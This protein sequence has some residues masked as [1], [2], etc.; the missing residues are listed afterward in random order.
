MN[1]AGARIEVPALAL[2]GVAKSYG[3]TRALLG[4]D[5]DLGR[6]EVLG[7]MGANGA[8]KSTLAKI[9]CGVERADAGTILLEGH[10]IAPRSPAEA[11]SAGIVAVH[12]SIAD[13]GVAAL[14]VTD[15]L[16]LDELCSGRAPILLRRAGLRAR[17]RAMA[18]AVGLEVNLDKKL[19]A[20]SIADRQL[21]AIARAVAQDP[22]VMLFDEPTAS[23][24]SAESG[25]LFG[26]I[27][28]LRRRGVAI[29]Y[30][31]HKTGDLRRLADRC[32]VLRDGQVAGS[33]ARPIDFDAAIGTMVGRA[34]AGVRPRRAR[35]AGG[36][37]VLRLAGARL[38][39]GEAEFDL[40]VHEGEV[41]AVTGPVGAGKTSLAGAIFGRWAL[42]AGSME[43]DG[44]PWAP[45]DPA[46]AIRRGVFHAGEDRWRSSFFP[47]SVPWASI[48]GTIGFPFLPSWSRAG[49]VDW[50][51][52]ACAG[53][54]AI[55]AFGIKARG[56]GDRLTALSGGNQQK[57]VLARWYAAPAR[58]L[59]LDEPFQ[60][61]DVGARA[62]LVRAIRR[63]ARGR[64]TIVF[65][66]DTEEALEIGDRVVAM[67]HGV[68][69]PGLRQD[70]S[71]EAAEPLLA[72][73][74]GQA[75]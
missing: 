4:V 59:L 67:E 6:G 36:R 12:Q 44:A 29:V 75:A 37:S 58:L 19:A 64:A 50:N 45:R 71:D 69:R 24:S 2:R 40:D 13:V 57:V 42:S 32:V 14:S 65:V 38:R 22:K 11:R 33:Y 8:G 30:I 52:E 26:V 3:P 1:E 70:G 41:L 61:V 51:R 46:E 34:L 43:L 35:A 47:A 20:L 27:D 68:V 15:N 72:S 56:P 31:S 23:L 60:G 55:A 66:N 73:C 17:A 63:E 7:L 62:D 10:A 53:R 16:L 21:V 39:R 28:G 18:E 9:L 25:R 48:A 54:D 5:L 49:L 74:S